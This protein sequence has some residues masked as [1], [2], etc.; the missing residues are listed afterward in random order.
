MRLLLRMEDRTLGR[1]NEAMLEFLRDNHRFAD[2]FNGGMFAGMRVVKA[3]ELREASE[4]YTEYGREMESAIHKSGKGPTMLTRTRDIKKY[5]NSGT[6]LRILAVEEQSLIDYTMPWRCMNYDSLEYGRQ[7]RNRRRQNQRQNR[8]SSDSERMCRF[9]KSDRLAPVYTICL[10]HGAER[11]DGPRSLKE[12]MDFGSDEERIFWERK[13]SDYG[14]QLICVNELED[15]S[16]FTTELKEL[17]AV[18]AY[19]KDKSGMETFLKH[20]EEYKSLDEET[21]RTVGAVLGVNRF[22]EN[23]ERFKEGKGYNMCQA[24]QEMLQDS[25]NEGINQ[26]LSQGLDRGFTLSALVVHLVK[27]GFSDNTKIADHCGC[28]EEQVERIRSIFGI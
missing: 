21:A 5:L 7:V 1:E 17:F 24:I 18:M 25:M 19:R 23:K 9:R 22:M 15:V 6:E 8:Y 3:E 12:M 28:T 11:W 26:G 20:H 16:K 2:L 13:F 27:S 14:M 10:Y 4:T